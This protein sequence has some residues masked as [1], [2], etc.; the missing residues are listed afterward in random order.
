MHNLSVITHTLWVIFFLISHI[1]ISGMEIEK[2]T[3]LLNLPQDMIISIIC[4]QKSLEK[5]IKTTLALT[6]TCK[7]FNTTISPAMVGKSCKKY[8]MSDKDK[9]MTKLLFRENS[10][11]DVSTAHWNKRHTAFILVHAGAD[12]ATYQSK[13]LLSP[14]IREEDKEMITALFENNAN[15]NH[16]DYNGNP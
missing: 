7:Q 1:H 6:T 10:F 14:A 13:N 9:V 15:P 12:N 16:Q 3:T 8:D 11:F 5:A 2:K 4:S